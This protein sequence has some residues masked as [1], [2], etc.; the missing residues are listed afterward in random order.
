MRK[1]KLNPDGFATSIRTLV[2][3]LPVLIITLLISIVNIQIASAQCTPV[4]SNIS[5]S[6]ILD[7]DFNGMLDLTDPGLEAIEIFVYDQNGLL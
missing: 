2:G 3:T 5:G 6:V 4:S 7:G 1:L